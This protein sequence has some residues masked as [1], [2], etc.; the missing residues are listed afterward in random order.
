MPKRNG[1]DHYFTVIKS[2]IPICIHISFIELLCPQIPSSLSLPTSAR[3]L[4]SYPSVEITPP[5]HPTGVSFN[6]HPAPDT[7]P[8]AFST[9]TPSKQT[10]LMTPTPAPVQIPTPA[11]T[12][13]AAN[14]PTPA[15]VPTPTPAPVQIPTPANTPTAANTPTPAPVPTPTPAPVPTPTPANTPT[16]GPVPI[17]SQDRNRT[18]CRGVRWGRGRNR[19]WGRGVRCRRGV[20]WG[21]DL[22]RSWGRGRGRVCLLGSGP[23]L[24]SGF[25]AGMVTNETPLDAEEGV[26]D[27]REEGEEATEWGERG[28]RVLGGE[29]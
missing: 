29:S 14:T 5:P 2:L 13:T 20:R 27:G 21:R 18:W 15:P 3:L 25:G 10:R 7:R 12:P 19:S 16:P 9:R 11:N 6:D 24:G 17:L 8:L 22:N 26:F 23:E 28:R 1:E 4:P